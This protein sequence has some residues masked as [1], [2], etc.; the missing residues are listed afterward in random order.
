MEYK[1][2]GALTIIPLW[3]SGYGVIIG[4]VKEL[5][6]SISCIEE[7]ICAGSWVKVSPEKGADSVVVPAVEV[8][9]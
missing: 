4:M 6:L 1:A 9:E 5:S 3:I 7:L 2:P 8:F